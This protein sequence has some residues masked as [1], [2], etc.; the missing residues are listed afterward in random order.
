MNRDQ[1]LTEINRVEQA[2]R[3]TASKKLQRDYGKH[4]KRL[5]KELRYYDNAML[6]YRGENSAYNA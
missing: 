4:L 6:R 1:L 5:Y 2:L 3:K